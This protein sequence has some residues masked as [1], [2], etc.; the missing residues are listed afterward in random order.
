[1][2]VNGWARPGFNDSAWHDA[3]LV[4]A[5]GGVLR[6]Q[7]IDPIRVM[8]T[9]HP[10]AITT[11]RPGVYIFDMVQNMVGWCRLKVR[12]PAGATVQLRHAE[13]LRPD[14]TLYTDNLRSAKATDTYILDGH[15]EEIYE[16]RFTYHGFRYVEVTGFPGKPTLSAIE[17]RVV[18]DSLASTGSFT[19]SDP[20]LNQIYHNIWWGTSGNYR[21]IPT[22]CPQRDERQGWLGD[23]S[24][25][26]WGESF[27]FDV[28][29]F[30]AKWVS[31]I[32]DCQRP[33]GSIG[34]VAPAYWQF[35]NDG[36]VWPSTFIIVPQMVYE[37]YGDTTV[38]AD[39]YP[40]M[41][42]WIDYMNGFI[43]GGIMPRNSYGDWC[44][45]PKSPTRIQSQDPARQTPGDLISTA[46]YYFDLT[47]MAR[48]A[49]VLNK[50]D[51]AASFQKMADAMKAAFNQRFYRANTTDYGNGSQTSSLLPL[52]FGMAPPEAK[53]AVFDA[54]V[55]KI[56][57]GSA[58]HIGT[59]LVGGQ[60]L[61]QTLSHDGA[62]NLAYR[63]ANQTTYPSWGYM[64][65][66][67]ATT[68]WELWNG[69]TANPA[70]NS[71]NH[72]MLIGDLT[73]WLFE[74][75]AGIRPDSEHPGFRHIIL[76]PLLP[77]GLTSVTAHHDTVYGRILSSW[78]N[79]G[80]RLTWDIQ[81][82]VNT[83]ATVYVPAASAASVTEGGRP[84]G[85][86]EAVKFLRMEEG[87]AIY[88][89]GSGAYHFQSEE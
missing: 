32:Q 81:V 54:L 86:S 84:A 46:Y 4:A 22:D 42:H 44:V 64:I 27:L 25:E 83:T 24:A 3:E 59:G 23:R 74:S 80:G 18:H 33:S 48:T 52:A 41:K 8:Q 34:D 68:M 61:M 37:Q 71:G 38:L 50:P 26:C 79:S 72:V 40:A 5:P 56:E 66:K 57:V 45:P 88:E 76:R 65:S 89:I 2:E 21:S 87:N 31:D 6:A 85:Q 11:P 29:K 47:L 20:L 28:S 1:M 58:G 10:V 35:Y 7:P 13:R 17:G 69:D 55:Q 82:P 16:P 75:L 30:Y 12:G 39:H 43:A 15:G 62:L 60:W 70:M 53:Q 51:D 78:T 67:G 49:T 77:K 63:I 9:L 73:T 19:C 14:G 36:V